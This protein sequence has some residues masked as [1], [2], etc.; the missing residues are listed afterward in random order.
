MK[1]NIIYLLLNQLVKVTQTNFVTRFLTPFSMLISKKTLKLALLPKL[2]AVTVSSL[3]L[4]KLLLPPRILILKKSSNASLA[5]IPKS[6]LKS[7]SNPQKLPR[8]SIPAAL[9]TR[10]S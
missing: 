1:K 5:K 6:T 9:A 8:A 10:E 7:L 4:A 3:L 2:A